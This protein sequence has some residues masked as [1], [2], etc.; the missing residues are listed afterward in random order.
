MSG[1]DST[2]DVTCLPCI[3]RANANTVH[4]NPLPRTRRAV[5]YAPGA[6]VPHW[7]P[8]CGTMSGSTGTVGSAVAVLRAC[9]IQVGSSAPSCCCLP[10]KTQPLH[11]STQKHRRTR[12]AG[13]VRDW[14][15]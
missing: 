14:G 8:V 1:G 4:D 13:Q 12:C 10:Q 15:A 11:Q 2:L 9:G 6:A 5:L 3:L 7:Q